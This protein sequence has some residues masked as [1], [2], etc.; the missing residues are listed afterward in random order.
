MFKSIR[1]GFHQFTI[2]LGQIVGAG[3][4][5]FKICLKV[6]EGGF[7]ELTKCL[8]RKGLGT[9]EYGVPRFTII[10]LYRSITENDAS[11]GPGQGSPFRQFTI[12]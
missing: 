12:F 8:Q 4:S 3:F 7:H 11:L 10:F 5:Q 6:M 1:V 2:C 9:V